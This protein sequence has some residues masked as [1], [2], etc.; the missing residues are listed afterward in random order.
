MA[1]GLLCHSTTHSGIRALQYAVPANCL[2]IGHAVVDTSDRAIDGGND[3]RRIPL[4][5]GHHW[6]H[7][8]C[9]CTHRTEHHHQTS[10]V[11]RHVFVGCVSI[12]TFHAHYFKN[13]AGSIMDIETT[14][15]APVSHWR[16]VVQTYPSLPLWIITFILLVIIEIRLFFYAWYRIAF[17]SDNSGIIQ[18]EKNPPSYA[19]CISHSSGVRTVNELPTY[20]EALRRNDPQKPCCSKMSLTQSALLPSSSTSS[21]TTSKNALPTMQK[22]QLKSYCVSQLANPFQGKR[23]S[24]TLERASRSRSQRVVSIQI[25]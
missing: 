13:S 20:E 1:S 19:Y 2:L 25:E 21:S 7:E 16:S 5:N 23:T 22:S 4:G 8:Q 18:V 12:D 17:A 11:V 14:S 6:H 3:A 9:S 10:S 24:S 15:K